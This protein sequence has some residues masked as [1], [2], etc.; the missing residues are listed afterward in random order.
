MYAILVSTLEIYEKCV[1][2]NNETAKATM[3]EW[4][5]TIYQDPHGRFTAML[6]RTP[7]ERAEAYKHIR[8]VFQSTTI[9]M[10]TL[11]VDRRY[12]KESEEGGKTE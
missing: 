1:E 7:K 12:L 10:K 4:V 3:K 9:A 8:E 5:D 6:Y 2:K 11:H